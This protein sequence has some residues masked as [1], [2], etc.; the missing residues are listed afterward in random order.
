MAFN[1]EERRRRARQRSREFAAK[2]WEDLNDM[3]PVTCPDEDWEVRRSKEA[4]FYAVRHAP[5]GVIYFL[6][7]SRERTLG[8][9]HP[10]TDQQLIELF[11][12]HNNHC[13]DPEGI[14]FYV[15]G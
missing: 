10:P 4:D 13:H 8:L 1:A 14:V 11:A 15:P 7:P 6:D 12:R 9:S 3:E 5:C 2:G